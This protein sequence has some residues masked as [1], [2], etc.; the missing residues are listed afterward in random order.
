[1]KPS[2]HYRQRFIFGMVLFVVVLTASVIITRLYPWAA[3]PWD[4]IIMLLPVFPGIYA[5]LNLA[6]GVMT[7]DE[8][9]QRIQLEAFRFS[10]A[11]TA[12]VAL[13]L[14]LLQARSSTSINF[15]WVIPMMAFFWGL[16][17]WF[18]QRRYQ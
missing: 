13:V 10:L 14:G 7:L 11:N 9:Q 16:G 2:T 6:R 12:F 18:A 5:G 8:L 3:S 15:V 1:M 17:L 4:T